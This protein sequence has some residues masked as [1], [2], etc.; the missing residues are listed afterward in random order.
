[1]G[2]RDTHPQPAVGGERAVK[3]LGKFPVAVARK[4]IIVAEPRADFFDRAA[5]RLLKLGKGEVD[6]RYSG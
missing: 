4:P 6:C 5:Y 3:L 2:F 1:M